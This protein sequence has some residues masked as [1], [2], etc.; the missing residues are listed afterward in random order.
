M[1]VTSSNSV[2]DYAGIPPTSRLPQFTVSL[3]VEL[4][5]PHHT[6]SQSIPPIRFLPMSSV[7]LL[8][9]TLRVQLAGWRNQNF[10]YSYSI[11]SCV[12]KDAQNKAVNPRFF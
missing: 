3:E 11:F 9:N 7:L 1:R 4:Q 8:V 10:I 12:K 2:S 5:V 6:V